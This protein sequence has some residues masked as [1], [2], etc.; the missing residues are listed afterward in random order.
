M[1]KVYVSNDDKP[2]LGDIK[3]VKKIEAAPGGMILSFADYD[4]AYRAAQTLM[5]SGYTTVQ[6]L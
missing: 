1:K 2:I 4:R 3:G 5:N 6:I